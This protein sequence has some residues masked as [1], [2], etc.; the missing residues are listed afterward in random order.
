MD[1][2]YD[3]RVYLQQQVEESINQKTVEIIQKAYEIGLS[4]EQI[5]TLVG[6]EQEKVIW[7]IEDNSD[8]NVSLREQVAAGVERSRKENMVEVVQKFVKSGMS[9]KELSNILQIPVQEIDALIS[10]C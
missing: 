4:L 7:N 10:R 3:F 1:K 8:Y 2:E 9:T 6:W 5:S